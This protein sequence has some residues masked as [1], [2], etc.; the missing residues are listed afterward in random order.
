MRGHRLI[1]IEDQLLESGLRPALVSVHESDGQVGNAGGESPE[2]RIAELEA[3]LNNGN[4][5][6]GEMDWISQEIRYVKLLQRTESVSELLMRTPAEPD[7]IFLDTFDTGDKVAIIASSKMKK[8]F[9]LLQ[10]ALSLA[11]GRDFL[12]WKVTKP[13]RVVHLQLEIQPNHFHKRVLNISKSL[14]INPIELGDRFHVIN[15]RGIG[16]EGQ[17]GINLIAR[18]VEPYEPEFISF[19]PLYKISGGSENDIESGKRIFSAFDNLIARTGAALAYVHHD[20]KGQSGDRDIRDRGAGSNIIGRDYDACI[21]L[22][23]H[24]SN[25][26]AIVVDTMLRN[27]RPQEPFVALWVEDEDGGYRFEE[28]QDI[29]PN[30]KTSQTK[31]P[32]A[33]WSTY[34][35]AATSILGDNEIEMPQFKEQFKKKTG[36]SDNRM[37]EFIAWA[38]SGDTPALSSRDERGIGKHKKWLKIG[39]TGR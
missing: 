26:S 18:A 2:E 1:T 10:F 34:L 15:C 16:L 27:Y 6:E 9:F 23:P 24:A 5:E 20:A 28:R 11:A 22:T 13:R 21:T 30:K 14:G 4:L 19:D 17:E 35:P 36:L 31:K 8:S 38:T 25:E 37:K 12:N 7:Q 39:G 3:R 33:E 29:V 32:A